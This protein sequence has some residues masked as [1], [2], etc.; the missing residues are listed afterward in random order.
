MSKSSENLIQE[1]RKLLKTAET[2]QSGHIF[3]KSNPDK[4][5]RFDIGGESYQKGEILEND[6]INS[7]Y[8]RK[9][10]SYI[11]LGQFDKFDKLFDELQKSSL[12]W[13]CEQ[14][15]VNFVLE[16]FVQIANYHNSVK[17]ALFFKSFFQRYQP[18]QKKYLED[19]LF[20]VLNHQRFAGINFDKIEHIFDALSELD[21]ELFEKV[22]LSDKSH[23]QLFSAIQEGRIKAT[24]KVINQ[25][26][27]LDS[28]KIA[29]L[30]FT[31][32]SS[33]MTL[34]DKVIL[35][36]TRVVGLPGRDYSGNI[37]FKF[38]EE[39]LQER[40]PEL[41]DSCEE[42]LTK[43]FYRKYLETK[44]KPIEERVALRVDTNF[45]ELEESEET[46]PSESVS[47]FR[48]VSTSGKESGEVLELS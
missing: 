28:A 5:A 36:S 16:I 22:L 17:A 38:L 44:P 33:K 21:K 10:L 12:S 4:A 18:E 47:G 24:E 3:L 11:S 40:L 42:E 14:F 15:M 48:V 8:F 1:L 41:I 43:D 32:D 35:Q 9:M 19:S 37:I 29:E 25:Y 30:F 20:E 39:K 6:E 46:V 23:K 34:L 27:K 7:Q 45:S 31:Q 13:I 26:N 2:R